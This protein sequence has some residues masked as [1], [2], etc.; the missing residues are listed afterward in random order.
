MNPDYTQLLGDENT[1]ME[2]YRALEERQT[3]GGSLLLRGPRCG[4]KSL[5]LDYLSYKAKRKIVLPPPT[6]GISSDTMAQN[7][8]VQPTVTLDALANL[9][10]IVSLRTPLHRTIIFDD[11]SQLPLT[12][13]NSLLK[14]V[15][16]PFPYTTFVFISED[17]V[18]ATIESRC[19]QIYF[20]GLEP[21]FN[22]PL[23][24]FSSG[25]YGEQVPGSLSQIRAALCQRILPSNLHKQD[26]IVFRF[27]S[28]LFANL[29]RRYPDKVFDQL[30]YLEP[31]APKL[32]ILADEASKN[33]HAIPYFILYLQQ[34][35]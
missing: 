14:I 8:L 17:A 16:E 6:N 32:A 25:A 2:V 34:S 33:K 7:F 23:S 11:A 30:R 4:K 22:A 26:L 27:L 29:C 19:V 9:M 24:V 5:V 3:T 28:N 21:H 10:R 12:H 1:F 15:E 20:K 13:A 31:N 18:L 35:I